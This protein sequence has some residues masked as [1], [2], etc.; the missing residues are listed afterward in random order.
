MPCPHGNSLRLHPINDTDG[1]YACSGTLSRAGFLP[2]RPH[3]THVPQ[4]E[5]PATAGQNPRGI[6]LIH[7]DPV[8]C[9]RAIGETALITVVSRQELIPLPAPV[10]REQNR[11]MVTGHS[12]FALAARAGVVEAALIRERTAAMVEIVKKSNRMRPGGDMEQVDLAARPAMRDQ[13]AVEAGEERRGERARLPARRPGRLMQRLQR[14]QERMRALHRLRA[15]QTDRPP[16]RVSTVGTPE[17]L[18]GIRATSVQKALFFIFKVNKWRIKRF[19]I[20]RG[21]C[22][23]Y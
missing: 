18:A 17:L 20:M 23:Y 14:R 10:A 12:R 3:P 22:I 7:L 21:V 9:P 11:L 15:F 6:P 8:Q 2:R 19:K 5:I 16:L 13:R 1:S 4:H